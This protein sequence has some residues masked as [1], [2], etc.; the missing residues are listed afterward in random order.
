[1][2]AIITSQNTYTI[3]S[4]ENSPIDSNHFNYSLKITQ[5]TIQSICYFLSGVEKSTKAGNETSILPSRNIHLKQVHTQ[6]AL[7]SALWWPMGKE[8][9]R[10]DVY[11]SVVDSLFCAP[12]PNITLQINYT[13]IKKFFLMSN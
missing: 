6:G 4:H 11:V 3:T 7:V 5:Q 12:E 1:M 10:V 9:K 2:H 13:P 8:S